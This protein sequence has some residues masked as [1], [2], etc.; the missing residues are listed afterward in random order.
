MPHI[1]SI[2]GKSKTGKTTLIEKLIAA[3]KQRGYKIGTV[4]NTFH[5]VELDKPGTDTWRH[6]KAGSEATVL[7]SADSIMM[8][9]VKGQENNLSEIIKLFDNGYDI[10]IIEGLKESDLPKIEVHR[11]EKGPLLTNLTNVIG[12]A[13]DEKLN[14]SIPQFNLNDINSITQFIQDKIINHKI[15]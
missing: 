10:I 8:I 5:K 11:K 4:K 9:K 3:L 13:T 12:I 6:I 7:N 15:D 1:I 14:I 2:V